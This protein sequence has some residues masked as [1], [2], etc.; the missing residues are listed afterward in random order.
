MTIKR[1]VL[2]NEQRSLAVEFST[3]SE[4]GQLSYEY[5]RISSETIANKKQKNGQEF[6]ESHKKNVLLTKIESVAKHGFRFIYDD[7][8]ED[9]YSEAYL[10]VLIQEHQE[11]WQRYLTALKASGHTREAMIDIKQL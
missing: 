2:D 10:K 5:L 6:I 9:I 3:A 1:L 4:S 7:G 11:R 8:H